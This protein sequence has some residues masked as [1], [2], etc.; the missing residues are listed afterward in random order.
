M[1]LDDDYQLH[2]YALFLL[3]QL[4]LDGEIPEVEWKSFLTQKIH[5][6]MI[7]FMTR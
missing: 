3:G 2:F 1:N 6:D 5:G 4:Y 7:I